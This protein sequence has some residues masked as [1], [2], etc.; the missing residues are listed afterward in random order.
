MEE[1][2]DQE[3]LGL[4][5]DGV[6]PLGGLPARGVD[7]DDDV[8]EEPVGRTAVAVALGERQHVGRTV[9]TAPVAVEDSHLPVRDEED[10]ELRVAEAEADEE[11]ARAPA[12]TATERRR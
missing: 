3:P 4:P 9:T 1:P 6:A 7:R 5:P 10:R 2:V 12:E 8:A 11:P